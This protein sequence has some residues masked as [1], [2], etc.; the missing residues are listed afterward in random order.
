MSEQA[1]RSLQRS[2]RDDFAA[3]RSKGDCEELEEGFHLRFPSSRRGLRSFTS[4]YSHTHRMWGNIGS[5]GTAA[6]R[7]RRGGGSRT[8]S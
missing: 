7:G 2:D 6:D 5:R 1:R 8:R 3:V 4:L